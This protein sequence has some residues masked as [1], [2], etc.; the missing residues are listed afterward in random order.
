MLDIIWSQKETDTEHG[1]TCVL[2]PSFTAV[3]VNL[4][5]GQRNHL[6]LPHLNRYNH[7]EM[8]G[9]ENAFTFT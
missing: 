5:V 7:R 8:L 6:K 3:Y 1:I 4:K 2:Y 9:Y